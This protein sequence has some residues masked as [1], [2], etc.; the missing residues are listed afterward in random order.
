MVAHEY[1]HNWSGNRV[2]C[3]DWF[4][5]SLKEGFTVYRD[6]EF[7]SDMNSRTAKRVEDVGFLRRVQFVEDGGPLAHPV[8]PESYLEINNFYTTTVYEKGAEVVRMIA[9]ILGRDRFRSGTDSYFQRHDGG[10]V[11][12]EDFVAAMED[13]AAPLPL[14]RRWYEQAGTPLL[15]VAEERRGNT[16]SLA[17]E[18]SCPATPDQPTKQP[19]HIPLAFGLVDAN[20]NDPAG[21]NGRRQRGHARDRCRS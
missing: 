14:F 17:I 9:T 5:L 1:F 16:L 15:T 11:T 12:I 7:S 4:Q 19:F 20:G 8:R 6:V 10:A 18:Q 3:R 21:R 13:A 2:T